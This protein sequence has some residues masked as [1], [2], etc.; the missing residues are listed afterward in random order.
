MHFD[1]AVHVFTN[2]LGQGILSYFGK[3]MISE[4][5]VR[6]VSFV[7]EAIALSGL[8][9][10]YGNDTSEGWSDEA[11]LQRSLA[12]ATREEINVVDGC[13]NS[14]HSRNNLGRHFPRKILESSGTFEIAQS[15]IIVVRWNSVISG[16]MNVQ[17]YEIDTG[18]RNF[19][20]LEEMIG[21]FAGDELIHGFHGSGYEASYHLVD[22]GLLVEHVRVEETVAKQDRWVH[23]LIVRVHA[24]QM[25]SE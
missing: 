24:W 14:L 20:L 4:S 5:N 23:G 22:H 19:V 9:E 18:V 16:A 1:V 15:S 3:L 7:P 8:S 13:V 11:S 12:H 21:D 6:I 25:R 10:L 17:G 2:D